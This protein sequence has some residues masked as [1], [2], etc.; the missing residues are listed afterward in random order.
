MQIAFSMSFPSS[1][2]DVAFVGFS[3]NLTYG[4]AGVGELRDF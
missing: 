4:C 3:F 1:G 2:I